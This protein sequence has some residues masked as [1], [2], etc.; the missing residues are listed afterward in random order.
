MDHPSQYPSAS[1]I[2]SALR[3]DQQ[4]SDRAFDALLPP[5]SRANSQCYWTPVS[6]AIAAA[7]WI[8][9]NGASRVLDIGSGVGKFC[10]IGAHVSQLEYVGVERRAHLVDIAVDLASALGVS[11]R[12]T[13]VAGGLDAI[14]LREFDAL[15]LYNPFLEG[16]LARRSWLDDT[17]ELTPDMST[18]DIARIEDALATLDVGTQLVTYHGYGGRVPDSFYLR[19]SWSLRGG[20][21][22]CWQQTRSRGTGRMLHEED[23][24]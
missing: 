11:H 18:N 15:Y 7:R 5:T 21:L 14:E 23:W 24:A 12:T 1:A 19:H 4:V 13:F 22:R 17:V 16:L 2:A 6:V 20:M 10:T 3:A 8:E 9:A